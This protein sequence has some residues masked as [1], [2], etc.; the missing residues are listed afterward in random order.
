MKKE[1]S[2]PATV[3]DMRAG[4]TKSRAEGQM[5]SLCST[6][7]NS[8]ITST[9]TG[10][11]RN[12]G[13][14]TCEQPN[15]ETQLNTFRS[16]AAHP[17]QGS[18]TPGTRR[19]SGSRQ[20]HGAPGGNGLRTGHTSGGIPR[21][22]GGATQDGGGGIAPGPGGTGPGPG[23]GGGICAMACPA[24]STI[25]QTNRKRLIKPLR[26]PHRINPVIND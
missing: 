22:G 25:E 9:R 5:R 17:H 20:L 1:D 12:H 8:S 18:T 11:K 14:E 21:R 13:L 7:S 19:P 2:L 16:E 24:I 26:K 15:T 23:G 6:A 3:S 10:S 4:T